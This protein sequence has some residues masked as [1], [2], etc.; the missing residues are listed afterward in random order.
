MRIIILFLAVLFLSSP[1]HADRKL[2]FPNE[3]G[4][5]DIY[6]PKTRDQLYSSYRAL[7]ETRDGIDKLEARLIAEY[8]AVEHDLDLGYEVFKAKII[9]NDAKEW[10]VRL[11]SKF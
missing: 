3:V 11:P 8:E 10:R 5:Y 2:V 4:P 7:V 9:S 6:N 1:V